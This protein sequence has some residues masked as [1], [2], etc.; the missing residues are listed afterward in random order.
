MHHSS[1]I[2]ESLT[3]YFPL[4]MRCTN[5]CSFTRLFNILS[6]QPA[7]CPLAFFVREVWWWTFSTF[8]CLGRALSLFHFWRTAL[9]GI[10]FL[11]LCFFF[12][13]LSVFWICHMPF[14]W[15]AQFLLRNLLTVLQGLLDMWQITFFLL[16]LK[17]CL[18]L[19]TIITISCL[20]VGRAAAHALR[21]GEALWLHFVFKWCYDWNLW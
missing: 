2:I 17:F 16:L 14:S 10:I 8:V 13:F 4:L 15:P 3:I 18:W 11:R 1:N 9:L 19:L 5:S 20:S 12:F 7:E 21:L 6:F